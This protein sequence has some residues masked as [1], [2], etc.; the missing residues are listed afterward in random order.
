MPDNALE[1]DANLLGISLDHPLTAVERMQLALA[2]VR[3][4]IAATEAAAAVM[5]LR[6]QVHLSPE[7]LATAEQ[8]LADAVAAAEAEEAPRTEDTAEAVN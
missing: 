2:M 1:H 6:G 4:H 5:T 7:W 3:A 8:L